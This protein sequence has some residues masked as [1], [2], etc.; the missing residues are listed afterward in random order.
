MIK[1]DI[2]IIGEKEMRRAIS[3]NPAKVRKEVSRFLT[4]GIAVYNK[5]ILRQPWS[6]GSNGGGA[7]VSTGNLRDTHQKQIKPF[8]ARIYPTAQYA[9]YVHGRGEGETNSRNGVRSRPWLNYAMEKGD[10][11]IVKLQR[12]LLKNIVKDLA[13]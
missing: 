13:R 3:R 8:E 6:V 7:P 4:R 2:T 1:T 10:R 11:E 9:K 5:Y 12:L